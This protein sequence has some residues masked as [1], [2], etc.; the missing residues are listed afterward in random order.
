ME[1]ELDQ[2]A[3]EAAVIAEAGGW[4]SEAD[5]TSLEGDRLA[6][7]AAL[8]RLILETD[9]GLLRCATLDGDLRRL[10][11]EDLR[12]ERDRL[13]EAL[14]RVGGDAID[15]PAME[16]IEAAAP[17]PVDADAGKDSAP[18]PVAKPA[19]PGTLLL[20]A[21]WGEGRVVVWAGAL[22][23]SATGEDLA[24]LLSEADAPGIEWERHLAVPIPGGQTAEAR[25]A[26]L[27]QT[28]GW[29]VGIG[30][31]QAAEAVGPSLR[32]LGEVARWGTELVAEGHMVPVLRAASGST[33]ASRQ[34]AGRHRVR[35]VP[36]LVGRERLHDLV[37][38]MPGAVAA[39]QPSAPADVGAASVLAGVVD[40]VSRAGAARL[41]APAAAPHATTRTEVGE[42]RPVR[43]STADPSSRTR[44]RLRRWART[45]S[46]GRRPSPPITGS[47][48]ACAWILPQSDGGWLLTVEATGVDKHPMPVEHALVVASG[49]KSQQ[50]EAQLR[51]LERLLPVLR[52]PSTR[53][54]QVVLDGDEAVGADVPHRAGHSCRRL[55]SPAAPRVAAPA[56]ARS[57]GSSPRR[58][59]ARPRS[60][61]GSWPTCGGRWCSTTSSSTR[62]RSPRLAKE[63]QPL[64]QVKGRWVHIDRADLA[65]AA[66][67]LAERASITQLSGAA[68]IRHAV[69]LEGSALRW[70][71]AGGRDAAGP[72]I[73]S[74]APPP[75]PPAPIDTP[76]GFA[77]QLRS[78]PGRGGRMARLP[79]PGRPRRLPGHGHGARQDA[80][81]A[82]PP[83]GRP[84]PWPGPGDLPAGRADQL[85]ERG[86][87][88]HAGA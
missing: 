78:L 33:T 44:T 20:Q 80:D 45:S 24:G 31:G 77:G 60:A 57:C 6:W 41:V 42:A 19:D 72:P 73:C 3:F 8:R 71:G 39:L 50:V 17:M 70:S 29:L 51:R 1:T 32:W 11:V 67:A 64:V 12:Q 68:V 25:S 79:R 61:C 35:W 43:V 22:G 69:G 58:S 7:V 30:A 76:D 49:T 63:A 88:L 23:L 28:L 87:P 46:A 62:P 36:A 38:R 65:A 16:W 9:E 83:P 81:R 27:S 85:G 56:L 2:I 48:S 5:T 37:T 74:A 82:G 54:G 55:R 10:A 4:A 34:A 47:V 26:P 84:G 13:S 15:P 86:R 40:A 66:A 59:V 21:S 18:A 52:R 14:R 75:H 53:R